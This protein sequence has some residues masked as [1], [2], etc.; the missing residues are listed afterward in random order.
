MIY[1]ESEIILIQLK[2]NLILIDE[3]L[4]KEDINGALKKVYESLSLFKVNEISISE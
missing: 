4:I 1:M 3:L 2:D